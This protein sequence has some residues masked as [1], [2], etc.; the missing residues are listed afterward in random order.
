MQAR[1]PQEKLAALLEELA[2]FSLLHA[3]RKSCTQRQLL[4][5]IGK[6]AF[7]CKV[8][9]AG[10]IF[11]RRLLDTAHSVDS[12]DKHIPFT[13]DAVKDVEWWR[14]F[15]TQWNGIAFFLDPTWT[16]AHELQLYTDAAGNLGYGAYWNGQWFSQP[17]PAHLSSK[18]I[19]WK[20]LYAIVIACE[21]WGSHW[22]GRRLLFHCDNEAVVHIWKSGRSCCP[23]LMDLVRALFFVAARNNFH[24]L[25]RHIP[26]IDN[27]I[28]DALSRL[29]LTKFHSLVPH[30]NPQPSPIPA[31]LT[32][33]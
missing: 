15:A 5:L 25:I 23:D 10:R 13:D 22:S 29:Q 26:G 17:W 32:F 1:L 14:R 31:E 30:A 24:V 2:Q 16:P 12:L 19:E 28:A 3:S 18:S 4:S 21:A 20:E 11:L 8:I 6:L 9:P 27:S 7:T 33:D